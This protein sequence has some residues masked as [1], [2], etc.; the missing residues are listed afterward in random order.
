MNRWKRTDAP[1]WRAARSAS[2][3][4]EALYRQG[5]KKDAE[6]YLLEGYQALTAETGSDADTR[7]KAR[8]RV[9]DYYVAMGQREKLNEL[10]LV[11]RELATPM[12]NRPN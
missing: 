12:R 7:N 6:K 10:M 4:G 2:A 3:L 11:D 9:V 1:A 8:Q 5:K